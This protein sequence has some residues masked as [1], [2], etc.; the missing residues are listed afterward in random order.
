MIHL[1]YLIA[2]ALA[3]AFGASLSN[4]VRRRVASWLRQH[5]LAK[6]ML[7]DV[8]VVLDKVASGIKAKVRVTARNRPTEMLS[9]E[10]TYRYDQIKDPQLR[11]E[12]QRRGHAEQDVLAL[13][14]T[15]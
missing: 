7:M 3:V 9:I 4:G 14:S 15:A 1:I 5:G 10:K 13:V 11:A 8:V 6:S 2:A 12:L